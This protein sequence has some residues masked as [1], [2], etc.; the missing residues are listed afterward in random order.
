MSEKIFLNNK[1][2][3]KTAICACSV[4]DS[5][6]L[7]F[8][9]HCHSTWERSNGSVKYFCMSS[10]HSIYNTHCKFF[11]TFAFNSSTLCRKWQFLPTMKNE[12]NGSSLTH[13]DDLN[14]YH[15]KTN[16]K[17]TS[18]WLNVSNKVYKIVWCV[19]LRC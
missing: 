18:Y 6:T 19:S 4:L 1:G 10:P 2:P 8:Y 7:P 11:T 14:N 13:A 12:E 5:F 3:F 9:Y 16:L 15:M 17:Q